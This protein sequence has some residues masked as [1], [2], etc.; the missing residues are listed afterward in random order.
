MLATI[1]IL[2]STFMHYSF[3]HLFYIASV[4]GGSGGNCRRGIG[5]RCR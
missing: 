2:Y 3:S 5:R 1:L 4:S